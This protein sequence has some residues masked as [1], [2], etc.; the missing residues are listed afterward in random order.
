MKP[1]YGHPHLPLPLRGDIA[2]G[3]QL[4][5]KR[6]RPGNKVREKNRRPRSRKI[7]TNKY[8]CTMCLNS[9]KYLFVQYM[10]WVVWDQF[11]STTVSSCH[12]V[13]GSVLRRRLFFLASSSSSLSRT[14]D[15]QSVC[16]ELSF[17]DGG[18]QHCRHDHGKQIVCPKKDVCKKETF[19]SVAIKCRPE[20]LCSTVVQGRIL[21]KSVIPIHE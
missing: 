2:G 6:H 18:Q 1:R 8:G 3:V 16:P 20:L 9:L 7:V 14:I 15:V 13:T 21:G 4:V 11:C 17:F 5:Q 12:M 10:C 19:R